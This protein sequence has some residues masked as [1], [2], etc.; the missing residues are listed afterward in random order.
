V[1]SGRN[2]HYYA[3]K[4][5]N[6]IDKAKDAMTSGWMYE[7]LKELDA[8]SFDKYLKQNHKIDLASCFEKSTLLKLPSSKNYFLHQ[9]NRLFQP[10]L[11]D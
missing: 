4:W 11:S 6:D 10:N 8:P 1:N 7:K 3:E 9:I 2:R 5:V